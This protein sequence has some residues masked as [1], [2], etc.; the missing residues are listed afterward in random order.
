[1]ADIIDIIK[2]ID[3]LELMLC[4]KIQK[5]IETGGF[6]YPGV[7]FWRTRQLRELQKFKHENMQ[8]MMAYMEAVLNNS[9]TYLKEEYL[10]A[11]HAEAERIKIYGS[12]EM[13]EK[14]KEVNVG[15]F[16]AVGNRRMITLI[17]SVRND[18]S[19]A[20]F[21][22]F[23]QSEDAYRD[24]IIKT[25]VNF[26]AGIDTLQKC[27][28]FASADYMAQGLGFVEYANGRKMPI[29]SYSEMA[30]RT[31]GARAASMGEGLLRAELGISLV[32]VSS[33]QSSCPLCGKWENRVLFDDVYSVNMEPV[34]GYPLLSTAI[35]EGLR[36]PNCRHTLQSYIEG[37]T[38]KP[39]PKEY[40]EKDK[41][42]YKNEQ[43]QRAIERE[44]RKI[45]RLRAAAVSPEMIALY[46]KKLKAQNERMKQ[47][48]EKNPLLKRKPH[49]EKI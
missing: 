13:L 3:N 47:H 18:L 11:Q 4:A 27:I 5:H 12:G 20:M 44:I 14:I 19:E 24:I 43:K 45:K 34:D 8:Y 46:D 31:N 39:T 33:H 26:N 40:T 42:R 16:N 7:D 38:E 21:S 41:E 1:M 9:A 10:E 36:H 25:A 17:D 6:E 37:I 48:L 49:R 22:L 28:D 30:L 23:R 32:R 15:E 35:S 29:R 2:I